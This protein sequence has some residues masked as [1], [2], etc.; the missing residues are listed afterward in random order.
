MTT[1]PAP[2]PAPNP[3]T[4]PHPLPEATGDRLLLLAIRRMGAHGLADA[5]VAQTFVVAFGSGFRRPLVLARAFMA[6][7]AAT[8]TTTIAIAPCC[9]A[10]MTWA[11]AALLTAIGH[12]ERRPDAAR[13][14]LADVMA[15]R[16]ADAIVASAAALS[17]AFAD[18]GL[19]IGG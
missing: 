11:E 7:L 10:R 5:H 3:T 17:A 18:L 15:E 6:E 12:A 19:P 13:L 9:C 1:L 16:R 14:L 2:S 4:L 8:A